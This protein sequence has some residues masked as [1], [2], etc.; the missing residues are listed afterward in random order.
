[1][2]GK[3]LIAALSV[4]CAAG[5]FGLVACKPAQEATEPTVDNVRI[6]GRG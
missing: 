3:K 5:A 1:M 6:G 4:V 2:R